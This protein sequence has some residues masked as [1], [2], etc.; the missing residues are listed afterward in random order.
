MRVA[1][2]PDLLEAVANHPRVYPSVSC[3]GCGAISFG[4]SWM[5]CIGL[6]FGEAGGFVFHRRAPDA[7]EVH[8]LFLPKTR[9][10]DAFA[11]QAL[12][13]MFDVAGAEIVLTQVA[14]DLPH[15]RRFAERQGFKHFQ[16]VTDGW[17]RESGPVDV[18]L[19]ELTKQ[20]HHGEE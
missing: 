17:V 1:T 11:Q 6:E 10:V 15:V 4:P 12:D 9:G 3:K 14:C 7:Y 19:F 16:T 8:T 18:D 20:M 13:Y 5:D 2:A